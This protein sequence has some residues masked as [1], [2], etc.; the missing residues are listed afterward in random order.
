MV[1]GCIL[2]AVVLVVIPIFLLFPIFFL[3]DRGEEW[4]T[5]QSRLRAHYQVSVL[6]LST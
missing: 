1:S 3:R 4:L 6:I 2:Q 5:K